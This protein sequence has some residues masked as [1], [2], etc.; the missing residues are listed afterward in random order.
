M[1]NSLIRETKKPHPTRLL[2]FLASLLLAGCFSYYSIED[3]API[4]PQATLE[5]SSIAH[6][7][8]LHQELPENSLPAIYQ[9]LLSGVQ[10]AENYRAKLTK[11]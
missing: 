11:L 2:P 4:A 9:T 3:L 6:R 8:S 1:A 5:R 7:G 10:F